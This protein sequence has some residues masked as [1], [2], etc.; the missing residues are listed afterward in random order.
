[1]AE[2]GF[3]VGFL[4]QPNRK[5]TGIHRIEGHLRIGGLSIC[6]NAAGESH[7]LRRAADLLRQVQLH[8]QVI[9]RNGHK[10]LPMADYR[11]RLSISRGQYQGGTHRAFLSGLQRHPVGLNPGLHRQHQMTQ[12]LRTANEEMSLRGLRQLAAQLQLTRLMLQLQ[13]GRLYSLAEEPD[14]ML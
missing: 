2:E 5:H 10:T 13:L 11:C 6:Q 1:M 8:I 14:W 12:L 3:G 4:I 9:F 7:R